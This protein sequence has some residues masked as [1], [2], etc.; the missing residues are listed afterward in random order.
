MK[1]TSKVVSVILVLLFTAGVL[2]AAG[3][4][5]AAGGGSGGG[6]AA[7]SVDSLPRKETLYFNGILWDK[8]NSWNPYNVG[9]NPFGI[10]SSAGRQLIFETLFVYDMLTGTLKPQLADSYSWNGQ[11]L[12]IQ[13]NRNVK[14]WDGKPMTAADVVNSYQ[15]QKTYATGASAW[16]P[17]IDS[18][19]AQGDYTVV[20]KG[21]PSQFNPKQIETS[22]TNLYIT[23]KG[24]MDKVVA[25]I[26]NSPTALGQWTN[27]AGDSQIETQA[28]TGPYK[29]YVSDETKVVLQRVDSYWGQHSSRYG[30]LPPPKY[31]AHAIYKDNAGGDAAFRAAEVDISQQFISSV[32]TMF[33]ANIS[34]FIPQAP[35]Y[36]PGVIPMIIY[37]TK[38]P[39]LADPVVRKAIAMALDY[40]TIGK[41][42]MSG[43]TAPLTASLML[44]TPPE[45]A[46]I[47]AD[48]LKPYQW[49]GNLQEAVAAANKLL[50]DAG[51]VKGADGIRAK[52]GVRLT[53]I[54]AECPQ[55]WSD[56]NASLEVVAQAGGQIGIDIQTYFPIATVW[57]QDLQNTTFDIIMTSYGNVGIASPW[58]RAYAAMSSADLP[59]E[60]TPN[61]IGNYGRW[62]NR[63]A[64]DI[65]TQIATETDAAKLKQ[66]WTRLNVIYLQEMP[67]AGLMYRPGVFHTVNETVWT[68]YPKINDGSGVPPTL[69]VDAYG[70]K[71]LYNLRNK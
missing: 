39:R 50:D 36:F 48:A 53:G 14:F 52:G 22:L 32:W 17:Y 8:V 43:Y 28:G 49:S 67:C 44:P 51:W 71:G 66:R 26:G 11:T 33:N 47:D 5:Q 38:D 35:Y 3:G 55:G 61:P 10:D 15:L 31:I 1:R 23:Q 41:N 13:L 56:W 25:K 69:C 20:I 42:A 21:N 59:P 64:T 19:A 9:A 70:I 34:T 27:M 30:K 24:E 12:T 18:V 54:R 63:E 46:L 16:W 68:G 2:F 4:G 62:T 7:T 58:S 37:N 45:Q 60:G 65:I 6:S 57:T 40:D 29:P